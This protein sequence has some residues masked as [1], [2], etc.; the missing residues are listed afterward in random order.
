MADRALGFA[1]HF[2]SCCAEGDWDGMI[3]G[4]RIRILR[5]P[6]PHTGLGTGT[7]MAMA[8]ARA[9]AL[10]IDRSDWEAPR[11]AGLVGRGERSAIGAYGF[12]A[13]GLLV[14]GGKMDRSRLAPLVARCPFPE[15]WRIVLICPRCRQGLAGDRERHVFATMAPISDETTARMCRLVLM[16]LLPAV[17]D[18]DLPAF[19]ASLYEL[20]QVAG[21]CFLKS[22]GGVF[23]GPILERIVRF[24]RDEGV[25]GVGQSSWGPTLY[26]FCGDEDRALRLAGNIQNRF[27]LD[28]HE[29][30]VTEADNRGALVRELEKPL[31]PAGAARVP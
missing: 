27:N 21:T 7:Q 2:V 16:G 20:Q 14:E 25:A 24:V 18:G 31:W 8:V 11:L 5:A 6:H 23:A 13:G 15:D 3:R 30:V 9:L 4:A 19:G 1:N 26:A 12:C 17:V 29:V 28:D 22:Q 10:L